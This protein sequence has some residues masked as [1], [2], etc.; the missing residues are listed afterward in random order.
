MTTLWHGYV[1]VQRRGGINLPPELRR[2]LH[3]DQPGAQVEV[4]ERADGVLE[5]RPTL[6]VPADQAW[7]WRRDWQQREREVDEHVA[8]GHVVTHES[9]SDFL[10]HL[11]ALEAASKR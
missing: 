9:T 1:G 10:S 8:N 7:F 4:T 11:D 5:L 2:R 3:L 6:A